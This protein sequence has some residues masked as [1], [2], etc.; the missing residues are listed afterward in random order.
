APGRRGTTARVAEQAR[1]RGPYGRADRAPHGRHQDRRPR[2][3]SGA[4]RRPRRGPRRRDGDAGG[5]CA[6]Q[7]VAHGTFLESASLTARRQVTYRRVTS[8]KVG[9][10]DR[11]EMPMRKLIRWAGVCGSLV[12]TGRLL[13][14]AQT[15]PARAPW[16]FLVSGDARNCGDVVMP[17]IAE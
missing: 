7:G 17:G 9:S 2:H 15:P 5:R 13:T 1:R 8:F 3:R 6:L 14:T 11:E 4:G 12:M 16:T 10:G